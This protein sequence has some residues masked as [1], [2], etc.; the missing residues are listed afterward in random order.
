[1]LDCIC[2]KNEGVQIKLKGGAMPKINYDR[3]R[4]LLGILRNFRLLD[5]TFFSQCFDGSNECMEL[6]LRIIL[7]IPDLKVLKTNTQKNVKNLMLHE[8][9]L[10]A[11]AE[12]TAKATHMIS[13]YS[14]QMPEQ[15]NAERGSTA[16]C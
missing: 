12:E 15:R 1:M 2:V 7:D 10:D 13:R 4:E 6:I 9:R 3:T 8:A 16:A 11:Y 14:A 5:D